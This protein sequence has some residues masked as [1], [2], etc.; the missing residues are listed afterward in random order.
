MYT[1]IMHTTLLYIVSLCIYHSN[2]PTKNVFES[3][4]QQYDT[5][6]NCKINTIFNAVYSKS[7]EKYLVLLKNTM[8]VT[9]KYNVFS[10]NIFFFLKFSCF[11][12]LNLT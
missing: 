11:F 10:I 1:S 6:Y 9:S 12:Y 8:S 5:L 7:Q 3:T 2:H 4:I